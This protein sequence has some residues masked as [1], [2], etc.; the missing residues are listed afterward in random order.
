[1]KTLSLLSL[2]AI[3][4]LSSALDLSGIRNWTGTGTKRAAFVLDFGSSAP[5]YAWGYY[6]DGAKTGFDMLTAI[7]AADPDL[8]VGI[9]Q[10]SFGPAI[11][12]F[13]YRGVTLSG[14]DAGTPGYWSYYTAENTAIQPSVWTSSNVGA[15]D[16][17]LGTDSWD[18]WSWAPGFAATPPKANI[19]P[20]APVPEPASL[21][22]LGLG[23]LALLRRRR[24]SN[25]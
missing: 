11:T 2:L 10:Y 19:V 20:A 25:P 13:T 3:P 16:R 8:S 7:D 14:F 9:T 18:G 12:R 22:A 4:A 15:G 21:L 24:P 6:Y 17:A 1:M 23:G 5:A